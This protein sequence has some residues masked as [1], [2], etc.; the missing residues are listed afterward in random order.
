MANIGI[1]SASYHA[2]T[3]IV[4]RSAESSNS[5]NRIASAQSGSSKGDRAAF[6]VMRD[7]FRLDISAFRAATQSMNV[8][9]GYLATAIT[10]LDNA[11][12]LLTRL[13]E[14]AVL[15]SNSSN[16]LADAAA[17][18]AEAEV[19]ADQLHSI[20]DNSQ[21]KG[22]SVF[23]E[24][25]WSQTMAAGSVSSISFGVAGLFYDELYDHTNPALNATEPGKT[26]EVIA[27]LTD[28][29]KRIIAAESEDIDESDLVV[30]ARFTTVN[31]LALDPNVPAPPPPEPT[32]DNV[33]VIKSYENAT[34]NVA[35]RL[36]AAGHNVSIVNVGDNTKIPDDI[37]G[38]DQV[39]DLRF[40]AQYDQQ[41]IDDYDE[42]IKDGGF[43]YLVTEHTG[44]N[45]QN[46]TKA[47][48]ITQM[49]GGDTVIGRTNANNVVVDGQNNTF[50]T[51]NLTIDYSMVSSIDNDQGTPLITDSDGDVTAMMWVG[52]A[53]DL[54]DEYTGT[55]ITSPD[56]EWLEN[57]T[58]NNQ[59]ALDDIIA[60]VVRGTVDGTISDQGNG[61]GEATGVVE[62][63]AGKFM[64]A[65]DNSLESAMSAG[66]S[67]TSGTNDNDSNQNTAL[68]AINTSRIELV[69][70]RLKASRVL[71]ASQYS[72]ISSA[73]ESV[74]DLTAQYSMSAG[75]LSDINFSLETA[76]LAKLEMQQDAAA[77][78]LA[79]A[80]RAQEGLMLLVR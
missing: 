67:A 21:Y 26:Y 73:I 50:M 20:I 19:L 7:N 66:A 1:S 27:P 10:A 69:H 70:D 14:L 58:D 49:G 55:V 79:Q 11:S 72:A 48:L 13:Q 3:A 53:G 47:A 35:G 30:G 65:P 61:V 28:E 64:L 23:Q 40:R 29:E 38:Y 31:P 37:T 39:W 17:I 52:N 57:M 44:F 9:K 34:N 12:S 80:N 62:A 25:D 76:K 60:G 51:D 45:A 43:V 46:A 77:A 5:V 54:N 56:I 33:L 8:T 32:S 24:D 4:T 74:T 6:E 41:S 42:F 68:T 18:D 71:A 78:I 63:A 36:E 75:N 2:N 59:T 15:G 22:I 16:S